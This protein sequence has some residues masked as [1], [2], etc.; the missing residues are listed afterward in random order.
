MAA[1]ITAASP[2]G[3]RFDPSLTVEQRSSAENGIW[4]CQNHGKLVDSDEERFSIALLRDW[5]TTAE[6]EADTRLGKP[7]ALG[8]DESK[9]KPVDLAAL[10]GRY[11]RL[12]IEEFERLTFRGISR[13]GKA[14]SLPLEDVYVEL[15][16]VADM[17]EAADIYSVDERRILLEAEAPGMHDG[18]A[19]RQLDSLRI[20]RLRDESRRSNARL[21]RRSIGEAV[22]DPSRPSL[23]I[24]G[25]PGSGKTTLLHYLALRAARQSC[26]EPPHLPIFVP[27]A[28]YDDWLRRGHEHL[29]LGDFLAIYYETSRSLPGLGPLFRRALDDGRALVLLDGLDEVLDIT[30]RRHISGQVRALIQP[31]PRTATA[32]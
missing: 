32:S 7:L 10:E 15:K 21:V 17:P 3:P 11:S 5:K 9:S 14:V 8:P 23:V 19:R 16:T 12:L 24:L 28:A 25:D 1:H 22:A 18:N 13:T 20:E 31:R 2:G 30:T 6:R 27:L 4:L 29:S 26:G